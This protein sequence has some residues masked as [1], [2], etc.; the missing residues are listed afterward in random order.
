MLTTAYAPGSPNWIDLGTPDLEA[1]KAF[2]GGVF[3][4]TFLS[5]GPEAGGYGM[6]QLDGRTV[7]AGMTVPPEQG[8]PGWSVYFRT[9][10][11]DATVKAVEQRGGT[12]VFQPMAVF[13]QGRMV[14]FLDPAGA[15]FAGWEPDRNQ[16][17]DRVD[18]PGALC[19][20]ELYTPEPDSALDF[21]GD[22]F[23]W[24][25]SSMPLPDGSGSY[26]MVH[27]GGAGEDA[28]FAG[29]VPLSADPLEAAGGPYWLPYFAVTDCDATVAT[30]QELGADIR[31]APVDLEGVGRFAK[32]GDPA[33]ARFALLQSFRSA[34]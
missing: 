21:Y 6:F 31:M 27:P 20:L 3:G 7:A 8:P 22:V 11:A 29:V 15:G 25:S 18:D 23:G 30:A 9:P 33:G 4:W 26:T 1:A 34:S 5:A 28:M 16:G 14:I 32:L 13:D 10:D 12:V 2:Y 24:E 19:W 17:L